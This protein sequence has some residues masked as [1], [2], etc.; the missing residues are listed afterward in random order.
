MSAKLTRTIEK[1]L[2]PQKARFSQP[3]ALVAGLRRRDSAAIEYLLSKSE[4]LVRQMVRQYGQPVALADDLLHDGAIIL[5]EKICDGVFDL[6]QATPQTYL[7]GICRKLLANQLRRKA[8]HYTEPIENGLEIPD[9]QLNLLLDRNDTAEQVHK[10]LE[11]LG[12]PC[13]DLI[14]LKYLDG[15]S[16]QEQLD[17]KMIPYKS[18]DSL[19]TTR[20]QCMRKLTQ[21]ALNWKT[22]QHAP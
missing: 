18:L 1:W 11:I 12:P 4:G 5:I 3:E 7:V 21:I 8:R 17:Q 9:D 6:A 2:S 15:Y 16:D 19:K 10:W 22:K 20:Y 13:S 14:R